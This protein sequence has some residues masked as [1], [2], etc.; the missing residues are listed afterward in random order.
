MGWGEEEERTEGVGKEILRGE[1]DGLKRGR[2]VKEEVADIKDSVLASFEE[3]YRN[4]KRLK[5]KWLTEIKLFYIL[6]N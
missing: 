3:E 1:V 6:N 2:R 4:G 5:L